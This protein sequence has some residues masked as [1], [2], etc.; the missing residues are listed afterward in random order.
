MRIRSISEFEDIIN[1][2]HPTSDHH[3]RMDRS[4][5]AAQFAPFAALSGYKEKIEEI[6]RLTEERTILS[7]SEAEDLD[8]HLRTIV[9]RMDAKPTVRIRYFIPDERKSGGEYV[10]AVGCVKK[11]DSYR[12]ILTMED[13]TLIPVPE[14]IDAE[15]AED[16]A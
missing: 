3:P 7:E 12:N 4:K 13:G 14:I 16:I 1:L 8:R 2:P 5:R 9:A 15:I 10:D 11:Y 6:Y